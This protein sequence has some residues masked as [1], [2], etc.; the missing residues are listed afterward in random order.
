MSPGYTGFSAQYVDALL[1]LRRIC[2]ER[3]FL[4][5]WSGIQHLADIVSVRNEIARIF[6]EGDYT[7]L[8]MVDGDIGFEPEDVSKMIDRDVE[9]AVAAPPARSLRVDLAMRAAVTGDPEAEHKAGRY[10][11]TPLAEDQASGR[12][13]IDD[14]GFARIESIG[15][16]FMLLRRA[17][18]ER[19][20]GAHP[21]LRY[22][23]VEERPAVSYFE[24]GIADGVRLGED[25]MFCRRWRQAGGDIHLLVSASMTHTGPFTFG[26]NFAKFA[27][28]EK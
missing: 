5:M 20:A 28:I 19:L 17:V 23:S 25:R 13:N 9:F 7:H 27:G 2:A 1:R 15:G 4:F 18:F 22:K 14:R 10:F 26:G 21:E 6:M 16:A 24:G 3:E 11:V 12:L 8:L